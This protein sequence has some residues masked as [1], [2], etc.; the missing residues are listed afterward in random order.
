MSAPIAESNT[1]ADI[2]MRA[3]RPDE[4]D[5]PAEAATAILEL[6][7][8]PSDVERVNALAAKARDGSLTAQEREELDRYEHVGFLLELI[9]SKARLSLKRAGLST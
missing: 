5:L 9:Q 7:L 4:G 6:E 2:L 3:I 8:S 1:E